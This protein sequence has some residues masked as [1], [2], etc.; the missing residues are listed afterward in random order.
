MFVVCS[1]CSAVSSPKPSTSA[2]QAT[3]LTS[4]SPWAQTRQGSSR[5]ESRKEP[6]HRS[7]GGPGGASTGSG[8]GSSII[9]SARAAVTN[10]GTVRK[11]VPP[12]VKVAVACA[13]R[14]RPPDP[15]RA[16]GPPRDPRCRR[17]MFA[18]KPRPPSDEV[19]L[20]RR[21]SRCSTDL[22]PLATTAHRNAA[23]CFAEQR[24]QH[25]AGARHQPNLLTA[26]AKASH[27]ASRCA[28][29]SAAN[30]VR[31]AAGTPP[32]QVC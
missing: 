17:A 28:T 9:A 6:D 1:K 21:R 18:S 13:C 10:A 30:S 11:S 19:R 3:N 23:L 32:A 26:A 5:T 2:Q 7:L 24:G 15:S 31:R 27:Q 29:T 20:Q 4:V 16:R 14:N 8:P 25:R 22:S 12:E